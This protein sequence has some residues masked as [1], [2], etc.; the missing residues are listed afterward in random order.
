[1]SVIKPSRVE[2]RAHQHS[3]VVASGFVSWL[4]NEVC[5]RKIALLMIEFYQKHISPYK[6]FSVFIVSTLGVPVAQVWV[7]E[8]Y[9]DLEFSKESVF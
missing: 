5:M 8:R 1:M 3:S 6:G 9:D 4:A 7:I 2:R